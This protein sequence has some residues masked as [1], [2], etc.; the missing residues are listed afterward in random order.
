MGNLP[1]KPWLQSLRILA[2]AAIAIFAGSWA[3][4]HFSTLRVDTDPHS[5]F[6]LAAAQKGAQPL[7][8]ALEKYRAD[9]GLYP[10]S[11][12]QLTPGYLA[13][14]ED[15]SAYRYSARHDDWI[16]QSDACLGPEKN[17]GQ[18]ILQ[19]AKHTPNTVSRAQ[20]D[21][22][23]GYRE[24][25]LQSADFQQNAESQYLARW[26]YYDSQPQY[27]TLGWCE[28]MRTSGSPQKLATNGICRE[29][30]SKAD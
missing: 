12:K 8:D 5:E 15:L 21:C 29:R 24:Y 18:P 3:R 23:S 14:S 26:A 2:I 7:L 28:Q 13:P 11:L 20:H 19:A 1:E 9:N 22:L 17:P 6:E 25:Q 27:W 10:A 16:L 30:N 4:S